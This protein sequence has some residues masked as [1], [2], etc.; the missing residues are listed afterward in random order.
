[1]PITASGT[2][3]SANSLNLID[4]DLNATSNAVQSKSFT[5][6]A[7]PAAGPPASPTSTDLAQIY[8]N[9]VY[10]KSLTSIDA[11]TGNTITF[12]TLPDLFCNTGTCSKI[13][14][15]TIQNQGAYALTMECDDFTGAAGDL[16][17]VPAYG[18]L[19]VAAPMDGVTLADTTIVL[20]CATS[21]QTTDAIVAITFQR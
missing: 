4:S 9:R 20:K 18:T 8:G 12:A 1:M 6:V 13:N 3:S 5:V 14:T 11:T 15:I 17:K 10:R 16:I 21:A 7:R 2:V 19:Q